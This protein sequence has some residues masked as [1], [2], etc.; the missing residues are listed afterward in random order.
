LGIRHDLARLADGKLDED[1]QK[2]IQHKAH[3]IRE[4]LV[5]WTEIVTLGNALWDDLRAIAIEPWWPVA[6][7]LAIRRW[8]GQAPPK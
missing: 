6:R 5:L 1:I 3:L 8:V 7:L 4:D 2:A